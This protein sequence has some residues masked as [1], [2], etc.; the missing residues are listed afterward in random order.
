LGLLVRA[1][2]NLEPAQ[3]RTSVDGTVAPASALYNTYVAYIIPPAIPQSQL[4]SGFVLRFPKQYRES[5]WAAHIPLLTCGRYYH[6][7]QPKPHIFSSLEVHSL[8]VDPLIRFLSGNSFL[9]FVLPRHFLSSTPHS[10][11]NR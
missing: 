11:G 6:D 1:E 2:R 9:L 4:L 7:N 3:R 8:G 10:G 5:A